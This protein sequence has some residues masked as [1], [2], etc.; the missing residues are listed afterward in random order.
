MTKKSSNTTG[1]GRTKSSPKSTTKDL[2]ISRGK[3]RTAKG[4]SLGLATR[5]LQP[6]P[7]IAS[8]SLTTSPVNSDPLG[9]VSLNPQPLPPRW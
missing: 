2:P 1:R 4:G 7:T 9:K 3:G 6:S 8:R 5:A